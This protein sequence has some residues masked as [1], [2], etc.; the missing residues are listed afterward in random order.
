MVELQTSHTDIDELNKNNLTA[1]FSRFI[2][3]KE[4]V[5]VRSRVGATE[6]QSYADLENA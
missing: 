3:K 6:L 1:R 4:R 2:N 5:F